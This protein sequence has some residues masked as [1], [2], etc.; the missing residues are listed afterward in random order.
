MSNTKRFALFVIYAVVLNSLWIGVMTLFWS[1]SISLEVN[2][3]FMVW[4]TPISGAFVFVATV[5]IVVM[6]STC[7]MRDE[8]P[9]TEVNL[10]FI[11]EDESPAVV[12]RNRSSTR[13]G[14]FAL[15]FAFGSIFIALLNR[16]RN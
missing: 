15:G 13:S 10:V 11:D 1:A 2:K 14:S 8:V 9:T 16:L 5:L 3:Q 4:F 6:G 12:S 7:L